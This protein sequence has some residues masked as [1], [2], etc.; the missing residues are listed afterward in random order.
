MCQPDAIVTYPVAGKDYFV[1]ACEGD[2]WDDVEEIRAADIE[3][4]LNR[5][6]PE[7]LKSL[8]ADEALLGRLEVSYPMGYNAETNTQEA[9][10]HFGARSFQ[11]YAMDGTC[12]LESGDW[13]EQIHAEEYPKIFNSQSVSHMPSSDQPSPFRLIMQY[14]PLTHYLLL[15]RCWATLLS[16]TDSR[17]VTRRKK[18]SLTAGQMRKV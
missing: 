8:V 9:L 11:I 7:E 3:N 16:R 6:I 5:N 10:Y 1:V 18:M 15:L 14:G 13:M 2:A 4:D 17:K 12:V